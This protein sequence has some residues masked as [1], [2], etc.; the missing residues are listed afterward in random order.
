MESGEEIVVTNPSDWPGGKIAEVREPVAKAMVLLPSDYVGAVMELCQNRRGVLQG[1]DYLSE[2]RVELRYTLP[3]GEII[4][5]FFDQLK[6]R[7]KGYASL[8]YELS[9]EQAPT[10]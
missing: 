9:G 3:M 2:D 1:M 6:S 8:D 5:D 4:F 7:T 10:W